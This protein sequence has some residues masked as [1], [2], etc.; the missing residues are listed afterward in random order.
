MG[1]LED[2]VEGFR[3]GGIDYI[4]KPFEAEELEARVQAQLQRYSTLQRFKEGLAKPMECKEE[5]QASPAALPAKKIGRAM[6]LRERLLADIA[7]PPTLG[8]LAIELGCSEKHLARE[9]KKVFGSPP[10]SWLRA[11]RMQEACRLLRET[12][13]SIERIAGEIGYSAQCNFAI[14]FKQHFKMSPRQF[15]KLSK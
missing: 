13:F 3:V 7:S 4:L 12:D 2:K 5:S 8:Q 14:A 9:F 1:E 10:A 15:R 11:H 6:M